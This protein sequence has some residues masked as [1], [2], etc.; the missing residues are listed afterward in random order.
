MET[1]Q[2]TIGEKKIMNDNT[3]FYI[4][5]QTDNGMCY[6]DLSAW[7]NGK[8][9]IYIGEYALED[10]DI[11][12]YWT[13]NEWKEWVKNVIQEIESFIKLEQNYFDCI[14]D[15]IAYSI[16]LECDWQDLSTYLYEW[17]IESCADDIIDIVR[18]TYKLNVI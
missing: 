4:G 16:L 1:I 12:C 6:K 14:V 11:N 10:E 7:E 13:K 17:D 5:G 9:I 15:Y 18:D 2:V 3:I 8:G